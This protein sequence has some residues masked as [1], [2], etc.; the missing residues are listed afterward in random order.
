MS[1][2]LQQVNT[3]MGELVEEVERSLVQVR[4]TGGG[5]G[6]GTIWHSDGLILTN[7]HVARRGPLQV[8]LSDGST[9]SAKL[10][11]HDIGLDL[12][13]L[14]VESTGPPTIE[15]G[16]SRR[17]K[18]GQWV[19]ALGHPWGVVGAVTAGVVIGVGSVWPKPPLSG[20]EWIAVGLH[21]RPGYS[22]GPLVDIRGK[23]V[24]INTMMAGPDV[25]VAA[26]VHIVKAF[27]RQSLVSKVPR[28]IGYSRAADMPP[29]DIPARML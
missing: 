7:A 15:L 22:G 26:P 9:L 4:S 18:P 20:G 25:G 21:L 24:G 14:S 27:L 29:N 2:V 5:A 10:L 12:A 16:E 28:S 13:A 19:V 8:V 17:L 23:L 6:A 1:S 11:A 3:Q